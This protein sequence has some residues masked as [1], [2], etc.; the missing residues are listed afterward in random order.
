MSKFKIVSFNLRCEWGGDGKNNFLSR[1]GG[2]VEKINAEKPQVIGFQEAT[3]KN[4]AFLR[5]TLKDYTIYFNQRGSDFGGEGVATA[6]RNG[7]LELL[8]LEFFWLSETPYVPGSRYEIQSDCPRICQ[9]LLFKLPN[10]GGLVR[11]YNNHL[12]HEG[13]SAR[14]LGIKQI[15]RRISEDK[16]RYKSPFFVLG[17]FNA[18]PDSETIEFCRKCEEPHMKDLSAE[19]GGTFHSYGTLDA[20]EFPPAEGEAP[21]SKIDYI[22]SDTETASKPFT[23]TKWTE[24]RNGVYLSD[25]YPICV[26]IEL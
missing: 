23:L 4:I 7:S 13:D 19:S 12:D 6:V 5:S 17:D 20:K 21:A 25:H 24:E 18:E 15:A 2:I 16:S 26:E 11:G 10:G 1:A 3:D 9:C 8:S 22:F 14:I